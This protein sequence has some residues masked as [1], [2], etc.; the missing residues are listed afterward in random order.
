M[1]TTTAG[2]VTGAV[3]MV[4]PTAAAASPMLRSVL[5]KFGVGALARWRRFILIMNYE[6]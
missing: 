6:L 4:V 3:M 5:K 1:V 2:S